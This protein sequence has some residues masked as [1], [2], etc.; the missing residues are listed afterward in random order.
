MI[1]S[2]KFMKIKLFIFN[3]ILSKFLSRF[4]REA[5]TCGF[6]LH[7]GVVEVVQIIYYI[8]HGTEPLLKEEINIG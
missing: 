5:H 3:V 4:S 1:F 6:F 2:I 7:S 8:A